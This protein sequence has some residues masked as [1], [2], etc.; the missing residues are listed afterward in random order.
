MKFC[1]LA[2]WTFQ[3]FHSYGAAS[4]I[5]LYTCSFHQNDLEDKTNFDYKC[6]SIPDYEKN[7]SQIVW[8]DRTPSAYTCPKKNRIRVIDYW[9]SDT[10]PEVIGLHI[11]WSWVW[12][13]SVARYFWAFR[14]SRTFFLS[15]SNLTSVYSISSP[16]YKQSFDRSE[17]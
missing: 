6:T 1:K 12:S 4:W 16:K 14:Q 7:F 5:P 17:T 15:S 13:R 2:Q 9:Y 3:W 10:K 11:T 8:I